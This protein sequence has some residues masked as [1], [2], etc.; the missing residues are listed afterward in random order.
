MKDLCLELNCRL[1]PSELGKPFMDDDGNRNAG[2]L[3]MA[4]ANNAKADGYAA[5]IMKNL[6]T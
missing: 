2:V 1:S 3:T 5:R 4:A 6:I